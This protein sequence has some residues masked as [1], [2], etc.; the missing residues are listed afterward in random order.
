MARLEVLIYIYPNDAWQKT[1]IDFVMHNNIEDFIICYDYNLNKPDKYRWS[2]KAFFERFKAGIPHRY[3]TGNGV[4]NPYLR[5][6][7]R[8]KDCINLSLE[9]NNESSKT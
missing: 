1:D 5:T 7:D 4:F 3:H 6:R 9:G 2:N 8:I